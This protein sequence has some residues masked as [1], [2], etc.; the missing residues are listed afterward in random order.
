MKAI[1]KDK[2][3]NTLII[4]E[5]A[6]QGSTSLKTDFREKMVMSNHIKGLMEFRV[7][8]VNH[9]KRYEYDTGGLTNLEYLCIHEN[10]KFDTVSRILSGIRDALL[11]GTKYML[12]EK[13]FI[14]DPEYIWLDEERN[15]IL[16]YHTGY[17]C[18]FS[19]QL[20]QLCEFLMNRLDYHDQKAVVLVYTLYMKSR[21]D[22]FGVREFAEY[23]EQGNTGDTKINQSD[24]LAE[25]GRSFDHSD[26]YVDPGSFGTHGSYSEKSF[27]ENNA[28][29][30]FLEDYLEKSGNEGK[31]EKNDAFYSKGIFESRSIIKIA[32][33]TV[34]PAILLLVC[35][36]LRLL[37]DASG[38][39]DPLKLGAVL[40]LGAT[41]G[42]YIIKK[43]PASCFE[44]KRTDDKKIKYDSGKVKKRQSTEVHDKEEITELLV[45][46]GEETELLFDPDMEKNTPG[47]VVLVSDLYPRIVA[48]T[49]PFY[50]GKDEAHMDF[51][52]NATGVSRYH[53]KLDYIDEALFA[54]DLNSKNGTYINNVKI[55]NNSPVKLSKGDRIKIG[56]CEYRLE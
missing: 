32:L 55:S 39:T 21:E 34:L 9:E 3:K 13:D 56:L 38:K 6:E 42:W 10:L 30:L 51:C 47:K 37:T 14:I 17:G 5:E 33:L 52:L 22:G 11:Q 31:T 8:I 18:I 45:D 43:L 24:N 44:N 25:E 19:K 41:V 50:I 53:L 35:L 16:V 4:T 23:L 40:A 12:D 36:K 46:N 48:D 29:N 15:P 27:W 28:E 49:F 2:E 7:C 54:F 1:Y 26:T 20:E